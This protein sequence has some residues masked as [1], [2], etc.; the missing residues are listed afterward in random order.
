M[1]APTQKQLE[2]RLL[3]TAD[4]TQGS[5]AMQQ[6]AADAEKVERAAGKANHAL[7]GAQN[8]RTGVPG[9]GGWLAAG[10]SV[11]GGATAAAGWLAAG[12]GVAATA[13]NMVH[14]FGQLNQEFLT[15]REKALGFARA[16]PIV[17]DALANLIDNAM[18]AIDRLQDPETAHRV[19]RDRYEMPILMAQ[20]EAEFGVRRRGQGLY[21]ESRSA[22]YRLAAVQAVPRLDAVER[23]A[24]N[25]LGG[26]GMAGF[27]FGAM[28]DAKSA[29]GPEYRNAEE[30]IQQ[31]KRDLDEAR[32]EA[33]GSTSDVGFARR[34]RDRAL[35]LWNTARDRTLA[36]E[37][38]AKDGTGERR[39][40][41]YNR[42]RENTRQWLGDGAGS[43]VAGRYFGAAAW[44]FPSA[45]G[46]APAA[47][48]GYSYRDAMNQEVKA[49]QVARQ[50]IKD[51]EEKITANKE[52]QLA[53][54]QKQAELSRAETGLLKARFSLLDQEYAR[55]R[56]GSVSFSAL[57]KVEQDDFLGAALRFKKGGRENVTADEL[58]RLQA[59]PLTGPLV[60]QKLFEGIK[61]DPLLKELL[62]LTGQRDAE[63]VRQQRDKL[64]AELDLKVQLDEEQFAK[65]TAEKLKTLNLKELL[66]EIVKAQLEL[67]L[68]RPKLDADRARLEKAN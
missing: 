38:E 13:A 25:A 43:A 22:E 56:S 62:T 66:G 48:T 16:L 60:E 23:S 45:T 61:S 18:D 46:A 39:D 59:N 67:D 7:A 5:R 11:L 3:M 64:K 29:L 14:A 36:E 17:G 20:R 12:A 34:E 24:R 31:A 33:E 52:K 2:L 6:L 44:L 28:L 41:A 10:Q 27:A 21:R 53:L 55:S 42:T 1:P 47:G 51:L 57:S 8:P 58:A 40:L 9:G 15:T 30:A 4:A 26:T 65:L 35:G 49:E 63:T 32:R 54:L 50:A 37:R 68:R 19:D